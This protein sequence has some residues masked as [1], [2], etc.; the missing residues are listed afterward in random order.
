MSPNPDIENLLRRKQIMDQLNQVTAQGTQSAMM[1]P[2]INQFNTPAADTTSQSDAPSAPRAPMTDQQ[3]DE[4]SPGFKQL[5][6]GGRAINNAMTQGMGK[7]A[8]GIGGLFRHTPAVDPNAGLTY[9]QAQDPSQ[10]PQLIRPQLDPSGQVMI[11]D[12]PQFTPIP[13]GYNPFSGQ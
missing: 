13:R 4:M 5:N 11:G 1:Q 8:S 10:R 6:Q 9:E 3:I 12:R 7:V 2:G